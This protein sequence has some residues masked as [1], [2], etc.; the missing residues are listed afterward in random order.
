MEELTYMRLKE[1]PKIGISKEKIIF[2][3]AIAAMD[4]KVNYNK[5][6]TAKP[7]T[8]P[9]P[10]TLDVSRLV[11]ELNNPNG[12]DRTMFRGSANREKDYISMIARLFGKKIDDKELDAG[13]LLSGGTESINQASWMLRNKYFQDVHN[14][15][16]R[17]LGFDKAIY[18]I[19]EKENRFVQPKILMPINQHFSGMKSSDILGI[20][21][22]KIIEYELNDDY[23]INISSLEKTIEQIYSSDDIMY[24]YFS[25]GDTTWGKVHNL[26]KFSETLNLMS[27]KYNKPKVP[28]IVDAAG[29]YMFIGLM[30]DNPNYTGDLPLISFEID[31]VNAIIGDPHKQPI[32]YSC[33]LLMLKNMDLA[34]YTDIRNIINPAYLDMDDLNTRDLTSALA[35]IP[36]S[37]SGVN[38]FN[39]WSYLANL[40]L[41]NLI[42]EKEKI[43]NNI[44]E[45]KE[46]VNTSKYYEL[47]CEPQTQVLPFSYKDKNKNFKIYLDIK[48]DSS[49]YLHISFDETMF[50]KTNKE[51]KDSEKK[52]NYSGLF[53]TIM[54]HNTKENIA[55]LIY[56]LD[57]KGY[58]INQK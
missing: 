8:R 17:K 25:A 45:L 23:D 32:P 6:S 10:I 38:A 56:N 28:I 15:N 51:K 18:K 40:G 37:R 35:T 16:I 5:G 33:G 53:A 48:N 29:A 46:Y 39:A 3:T 41:D 47:V 2:D 4:S 20:G 49:N 19:S 43:W 34:N 57:K 7:G 31:N 22:D 58:E 36:T 26:E 9:H 52:H 13:F 27:E 30:K 55:D 24:A 50:V 44:T 14:I 1:I 54:E 11:S 21:T 42:K 12:V